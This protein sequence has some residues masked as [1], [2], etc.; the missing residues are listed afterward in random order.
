MEISLGRKL[1]LVTASQG[2]K[3]IFLDKKY[4]PQFPFTKSLIIIHKAGNSE[5][6]PLLGTARSGLLRDARSGG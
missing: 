5:I 1:V 3:V 4:S 2:V 6:A